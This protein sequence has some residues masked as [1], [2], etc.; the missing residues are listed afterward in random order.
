MP[1]LPQLGP[2]TE[3]RDTFPACWGDLFEGCL[4]GGG[5]TEQITY[6]HE[7]AKAIFKASDLL[8]VRPDGVW[9]LREKVSPLL[10]PIEQKGYV[11][12]PHDALWF[13]GKPSPASLPVLPAQFTAKELA[14]C[15]FVGAGAQ[16]ASERFG[17]NGGDR[18]VALEALDDDPAA[19]HAVRAAYAELRKASKIVGKLYA[20]HEEDAQ[21]KA[22]ARDKALSS[23][24]VK[25]LIDAKLAK[26]SEELEA[27]L[28]DRKC[29]L[30]EALASLKEAVA[31]GDNTATQQAIALRDGAELQDAKSRESANL[32]R[33]KIWR[34]FAEWKAQDPDYLCLCE[35]ADK[36]RKVADDAEKTWRT[37]MLRQLL[38]SD[39]TAPKK[40]TQVPTP[41]PGQADDLGNDAQHIPET[42]KADCTKPV[43]VSEPSPRLLQRRLLI[44]EIER[45]HPSLK[46]KVRNLLG[47]ASKPGYQGLA[48]AK[49][50]RHGYWDVDMV[51]NWLRE[52]GYIN[53]ANKV[54]LLTDPLERMRAVVTRS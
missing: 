45:D 26:V 22:H 43:H 12:H 14:A 1:V 20:Q 9:L 24:R 52:R 47:E 51:L 54:E 5:M 37:A 49:S 38:P 2:R 19:K 23:G 46:N 8:E 16:Y 53:Q 17:S 11:E 15:F 31:A 40:T 39:Q 13:K 6:D 4:E 25:L 35:E 50:D 7:A 41:L 21:R 30:E 36:A 18:R 32:E 3:E 42:A 10:G 28:F 33:E 34:A 48:A 44:D 27:E 29:K